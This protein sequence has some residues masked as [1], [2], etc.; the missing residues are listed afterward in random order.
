MTDTLSTDTPAGA[1]PA[2]RHGGSGTPATEPKPATSAVAGQHRQLLASLPFADGQ[3]FE[4]ARRGFLAALEPGVV[5]ADGRVVWD[6]DAYAF[7]AGDAPETV[8]PS[9]WRQ[10][11]LNAVQGLF[12]VTPG[13]TRSAGSTCRTSRSS[14]VIAV[15]SSWTR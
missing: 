1:I 8:N 9:L 14:K 12:E 2:P 5:H 13:S 11:A 6:N 3:D 10:S 15:S 7:L 4:D